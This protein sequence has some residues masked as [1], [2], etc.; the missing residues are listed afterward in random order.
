MLYRRSAYAKLLQCDGARPNCAAC[1]R[2]GVAEPCVYQSQNRY[3]VFKEQIGDLQ[4]QLE[5][6]RHKQ[7]SSEAE[8][9]AE[10]SSGD[11][12][13]TYDQNRLSRE[14]EDGTMNGNDVLIGVLREENQQLKEALRIMAG[15]SRHPQLASSIVT[16]I[17]TDGLSKSA[18]AQVNDLAL[19]ALK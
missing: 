3:Q 4:T 16:E 15:S 6:M 19:L 14:H 12:T 17:L 2:K 1:A 8:V 5:E 7:P 10:R 18:E 13:G 9:Q 11:R